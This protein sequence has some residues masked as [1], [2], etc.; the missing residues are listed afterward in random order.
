MKFV[1]TDR[2]FIDQYSQWI[3]HHS[4]DSFIIRDKFVTFIGTQ[5]SRQLFVTQ[6]FCMSTETLQ[7]PNLIYNWNNFCC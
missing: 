2:I 6:K 5:P 4:L 7:K 3:L 1:Q